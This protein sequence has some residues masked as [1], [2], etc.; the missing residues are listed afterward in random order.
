M[1]YD[2]HNPPTRRVLINGE[3]G[4]PFS[5]G[6]GNAQGC[7]LSPLL[8][9]FV[10]ESFTRLIEAEE[11]LHSWGTRYRG[12]R[13]GSTEHRISQFADDCCLYV[14]N[15]A[16]LPRMWRLI[17]L[18]EGAT[19]MRCNVRKTEGIA[20]GKLRNQ[21][22][23]GPGA[24][25][26]RWLLEGEHT[27]YLGIPIGVNFD[28]EHFVT[29]KYYRMKALAATWLHP[30]HL[31][32][33]GRSMIANS[34]ILSRFR[35]LAQ[36]LV[37]P[38]SIMKALHGDTQALVWNKKVIF[39]A[40]EIG[41]PLVSR[42]YMLS[43][44]QYEPKS[45]L[46]LGMIHWESHVK[47]LQS[48][49]LIR[50][51][52]ATRGAW[53]LALD[54]W[55]NRCGNDGR[56]AIMSTCPKSYLTQRLANGRQR[57]P[58]FFVQA[59]N[60]FRE[61]KFTPVRPGRYISTDE[62][63][64]ELLWRSLRFDVGTIP[65]MTTWQE[66]LDT[67]RL[68]DVL[69]ETGNEWT[70]ELLKSYLDEVLTLDSA[71]KYVSLGDTAVPFSRMLK[72]WQTLLS[73]L[74]QADLEAV[75]ATAAPRPQ[76]SIVAQKLMA[77]MGWKGGGLGKN[78]IAEPVQVPGQVSK[79]GLGKSK[80]RKPR[81]CKRIVKLGHDLGILR[82]DSLHVVSLS[83]RGLP[84]ETGEV[85]DLAKLTYTP[86]LKQV[87]MWKG[88]VL[89]V[90]A[91]HYPH[92]EGWTVKGATDGATLDC[93]TVRILTAVYRGQV[94]G[95]AKAPTC[96]SSWCKL[97]RGSERG[98]LP[99]SSIASV[100]RNHLLTPKDYLAH[101]KNILHRRLRVRSHAPHNGSSKCRCCGVEDEHIVHIASCKVIAPLFLRFVELAKLAGVELSITP[102]LLLLGVWNDH[103]TIP[104]GLLNLLMI[105]YKFLIIH[106]TCIDVE[107]ARPSMSG[108]WKAA[109]YRLLSRTA[110]AEHR[111]STAY[112][113]A[114][115]RGRPP[116]G[117][118]TV[119]KQL[120]P[121]AHMLE[122]GK[123]EW[124]EGVLAH[125][126]SYTKQA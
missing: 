65:F 119:D 59:L 37:I 114:R 113:S 112:R 89:D 4:D 92:P 25:G 62:A 81:T 19:G 22:Y 31:T 103:A 41:T 63:R 75:R 43:S 104:L 15:F 56:G 16:Q 1:L 110:A 109:G 6:R 69:T 99:F 102:E 67:T 94:P 32:Q 46:G 64:A 9:L 30:S 5:L 33:F 87:V 98:I 118:S 24:D 126:L 36:S 85:I 23:T 125:L 91:T 45:K 82:G 29:A 2:K 47:A 66:T 76:Y 72:S 97:L 123:I 61:L 120:A 34:L 42:R 77:A 68:G 88:G 83:A 71:G 90:A 51:L 53:K 117:T 17:H 107:G 28:V 57:L 96:I 52:D 58:H 80:K 26:I 106:L 100:Y 50:Y 108:V 111:V 93:L 40:E 86:D 38:D 48:I 73:R 21:Q 55:F 78:G 44:W 74:P 122:Y 12:V 54:A 105:I 70:P 95:K 60:S 84:V 116:T 7:P 124:K 101:F 121:L 14:R 27:K 11:R 35:Y 79:L 13:I 115:D 3:A 20:C 8:F 49:I 10:G 18:W 39:D